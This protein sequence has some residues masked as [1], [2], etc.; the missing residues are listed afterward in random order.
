MSYD[1]YICVSVI[2]GVC[3]KTCY[4]GRNVY[5]VIILYIHWKSLKEFKKSYL[6]LSILYWYSWHQHLSW[7]TIFIRKIN[8]I[9]VIGI[10]APCKQINNN[11]TIE[12]R[13]KQ[14]IYFFKSVFYLIMIVIGDW[15]ENQLICKRNVH[16]LS[17]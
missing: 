1:R 2:L 7:S 14:N 3:L 16:V 5:C 17:N 11:C 12:F 13:N 10:T 9:Y 4:V 15:Y 6:S 8:V